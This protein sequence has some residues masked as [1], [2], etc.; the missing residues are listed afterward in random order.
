M[1]EGVGVNLLVTGRPGVGKTT[2]VEA[3]VASLPGAT[4]FFTREMRERGARLGF[5]IHTL[6]GQTAVLAHVQL[7]TGPRVGRYRVDLGNLEAVAVP[8]IAP[9]PGVRLIV[10]D[11]IGRMECLS[12]RFCDAVREALDSPTP[13]LATI[14]REGGGFI[15]EVRRRPD[16]TL[17]AVTPETR[18][19]LQARILGDLGL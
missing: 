7:R 10:V 6:D 17:L 14:A 16:V 19:V 4:G 5:S 12:R 9:R 13:L 15:A 3:V 11:E 1:A 8:A 18:E 2:L